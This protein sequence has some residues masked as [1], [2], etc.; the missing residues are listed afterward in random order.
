MNVTAQGLSHMH[1]FSTKVR[2]T[3]TDERSDDFR[4]VGIV[5]LHTLTSR[6]T[7]G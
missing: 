2:V 3:L 4:K 5:T 1:G 7:E 6:V